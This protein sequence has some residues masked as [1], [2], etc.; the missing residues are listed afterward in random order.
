MRSQKAGYP[1]KAFVVEYA[2]LLA[3]ISYYTPTKICSKIS[4]LTIDETSNRPSKG[5]TNCCR[6][7]K[8]APACTCLIMCLVACYLLSQNLTSLDWNPWLSDL[9]V[10]CAT[11]SQSCHKVFKLSIYPS[12]PALLRFRQQPLCHSFRTIFYLAG[13]HQGSFLGDQRLSPRPHFHRLHR[14]LRLRIPGI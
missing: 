5:K 9:T 10:Q 3:Q 2:S 6:S 8:K 11:S 1:E 14:P 7:K 13:C 4:V 12:G